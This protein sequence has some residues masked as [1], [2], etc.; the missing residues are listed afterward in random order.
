MYVNMLDSESQSSQVEENIGIPM[1]YTISEAIR[2]YLV[3]NNKEGNVCVI[4]QR[5]SVWIFS[6][7]NLVH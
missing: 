4:C 1:M 7:N 6:S 2:D 5:L 3:E